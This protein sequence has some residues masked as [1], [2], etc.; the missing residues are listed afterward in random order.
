EHR[1][2]V[3]IS[4]IVGMGTGKR[5]NNTEN[6]TL[7]YWDLLKDD[8][9]KRLGDQ[10]VC[11]VKIYAAKNGSDITTECRIDDEVSRRLSKR[12]ADGIRN[13]KTDG[14]ASEKQYIFIEQA[15]ETFIPQVYK[16]AESNA[17]FKAK[18]KTCMEMYLNATDE[19]KFR[20]LPDE[21][22]KAIGDTTLALEC[23]CLLPEVL[24]MQEMDGIVD[25]EEYFDLYIGD[26]K[27]IK[28]YGHKFSY[29]YTMKMAA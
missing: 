24:A 4:S 22:I 2:N 14:F 18:V 10:K 25:F 19:E 5:E 1:W 7:F 29:H 12:I 6:S 13:W 20:A 21:M 9:I 8:L 23:Y 17:E 11:A 26:K 15:D 3:Y 28:V 27:P 16:K